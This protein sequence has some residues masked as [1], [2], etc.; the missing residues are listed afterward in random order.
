[1][2]PMFSIVMPTR[3]RARTLRWALQTA[4]NQ[5]FEDYEIVVVDNHSTD[6]TAE[7]ARTVGGQRTRCV[8]PPEPLHMCKNWD[9]AL[10]QARGE[11]TIILSDDDGLLPNALSE[12]A[13]LS[14]K[15]GVKVIQWHR[16]QYNWPEYL[17]GGE[18]NCLIYYPCPGSGRGIC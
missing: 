14:D 4:V 11:Y 5:D 16:V 9:F 7:V 3:S 1:M 12:A 2:A 17:V 6:D 10:G 8:Q 13:S 18:K 15:M